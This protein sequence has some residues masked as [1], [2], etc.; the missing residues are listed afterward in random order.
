MPY[1]SVDFRP[2][3]AAPNNIT[4]MNYNITNMNI[5]NSLSISAP[6]GNGHIPNGDVANNNDL[7]AGNGNVPNS[8]NE[9]DPSNANGNLAISN[10]NDDERTGITEAGIDSN[11]VSTSTAE[12]T[13]ENNTVPQQGQ[14]HQYITLKQYRCI[15]NIYVCI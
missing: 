9:S 13:S 15:D 12:A 6:P 4:N 3:P 10:G 11:N 14:H 2:T 8:S 7:S 5:N 1:F